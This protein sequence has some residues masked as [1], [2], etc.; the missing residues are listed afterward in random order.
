[1]ADHDINGWTFKLEA[2]TGKPEDGRVRAVS[3]VYRNVKNRDH[4]FAREISVEKI[5]VEVEAG[6]KPEERSLDHSQFEAQSWEETFE[7]LPMQTWEG[8]YVF[9][10]A[11]FSVYQGRGPVLKLRTKEG[12]LP[13][14]NVNGEQIDEPLYLFLA[15]SFSE[16]GNDPPHEFTGALAAARFTPAIR[17]ETKNRSVRSIR[18]DYRFHF[19][20]DSYLQTAF[21]PTRLMADWKKAMGGREN[22]A[23]VLRDADHF[24]PS[25][26]GVIRLLKN[27]YD[28][29]EGMKFFDA[30][31]DEC[32]YS[33][34]CR[35]NASGLELKLTSAGEDEPDQVNIS[36]RDPRVTIADASK[37]LEKTSVSV[38]DNNIVALRA[39]DPAEYDQALLDGPAAKIFNAVVGLTK[40]TEM[41]GALDGYAAI[42]I[43]Q[44]PLP[45]VSSA[46][47]SSYIKY[48]LVE[49]V[50][51]NFILRKGAAILKELGSLR[52]TMESDLKD[53]LKHM[54]KQDFDTVFDDIESLT[55]SL[56]ME[57]LVPILGPLITLRNFEKLAVDLQE[58]AGK[59]MS[60]VAFDAAE[61][62]VLWEMV[63]RYV[64]AGEVTDTW[65]NMHWWGT[66][67]IPSAPG[68]FFAV[69]SHFRWTQINTYP[70]PE[71]AE[72]LGMVNA[73][74]GGS[75]LHLG[76]PQLRSLVKKF[77]ENQLS[78]PLI[79][80]DIPNQTV[81]FA[82]AL[83]GGELDRALLDRTPQESTR[84]FDEVTLKPQ[85]IA[86]VSSQGNKGANIVYWV[87]CKAQ[88][89]GEE[90][91]KGTLL[92]NG[93]YFAH[94]EEKPF[95]LFRR[96]NMFAPTEG[97]D[98][99]KPERMEP[100]N[101]V[102]E[103]PS[104]R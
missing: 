45:G 75:T 15:F 98:L 60:I 56:V 44:P 17:F 82:I 23:L 5:I 101:L 80:P 78:G 55:E 19:D 81:L 39:A 65:D 12:V 61:K 2:D 1:M 84:P 36:F 37:A 68:A 27:V 22:Y 10:L 4:N 16:Y 69:H 9:S 83:S 46:C 77:A 93:F 6:G 88:R 71:E 96:S 92:V 87:S 40:P 66:E 100:Y 18:V 104:K 53:V 95:S 49:F 8:A 34:M 3:W 57:L 11:N 51:T 76:A 64:K 85:P 72:L 86:W 13:P 42:G 70:T 94:D 26:L 30:R 25:V 29:Y 89:S 52:A 99:Q 35:S 62:P 102:R 21:L 79:D 91:F 50:N 41:T 63:G 7:L 33:G 38:K 58:L 97:V 32:G 48:S 73:V 28:L 59:L 43:T 90:V 103:V 31:L 14:D 24:P 47:L 67:K 20:L 54:K 74:L